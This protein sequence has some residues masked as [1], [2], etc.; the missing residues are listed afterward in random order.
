MMITLADLP[1]LLPPVVAAAE[2]AGRMLSA[3]FARRGGPRG[4]G[5]SPFRRAARWQ[6]WGQYAR[7]RHGTGLII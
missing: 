3:E 5:P 7:G 2:T 1:G 4:G 6:I